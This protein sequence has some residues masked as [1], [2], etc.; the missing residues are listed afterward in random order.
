MANKINTAHILNQA[1]G[2]THYTYSNVENEPLDL[3]HLAAAML[4][5]D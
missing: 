4:Q 5:K 2:C 3:I 1:M